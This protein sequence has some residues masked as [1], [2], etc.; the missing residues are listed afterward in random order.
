MVKQQFTYLIKTIQD[1]IRGLKSIIPPPSFS[2]SADLS[3]ILTQ[4]WPATSGIT[5]LL[6][7]H[8][9]HSLN[10][11]IF[12][13]LHMYIIY[14]CILD[15]TLLG[16]RNC[17]PLDQ[18]DAILQSRIWKVLFLQPVPLYPLILVFVKTKILETPRSHPFPLDKRVTCRTEDSTIM[19]RVSFFTD[20]VR[21]SVYL[22][23]DEY[24]IRRKLTETAHLILVPL[25]RFQFQND[26]F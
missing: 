4:G 11:V 1:A 13:Q 24:I 16:C 12:Q 9:I 25:H 23:D 14:D 6:R 26:L 7:A 2:L 18:N 21:N 10:R 17:S 20:A 5:T 8:T 22:K 19:K 15:T 3:F